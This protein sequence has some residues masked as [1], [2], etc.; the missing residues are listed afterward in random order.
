MTKLTGVNKGIGYK[1]FLLSSALLRLFVLSNAQEKAGASA[2]ELADKLSN[3]VASLISIPFQSNLDYGIGSHNGSKYTL[4]FQPVVPIHLSQDLN[5]ISR[6]IIPFI[7]QRNITSENTGQTG[8][9]DATVSA[10]FSPVHIKKGWTWGAGPAFLFPIATNDLLG[11]HKWCIGPTALV[12]KQEHGLTFGFLTN[13][14]WS[15]TGDDN[16]GDVNQFYLQPFFAKSWKTGASVG[17]NVESTFN[18]KANTT[19]AFFNPIVNAITKLGKQTAQIGV[20]PRIPIAGPKN[21]RADWG[22]RAVF[23]LVFPE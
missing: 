3:P 15:F 12:L 17:F 20:G 8:L 22:L 10:W 5:L 2:Q 13:Q 1:V 7:D 4:N 16:Y 23:T 11:T 19:T 18:W 6:F 21:S 9:S 14:L